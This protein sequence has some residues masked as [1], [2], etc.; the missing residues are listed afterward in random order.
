MIEY[1]RTLRVT[2]PDSK[3]YAAS[4]VRDEAKMGGGEEKV[5]AIRDETLGGVLA[6]PDFIAD[7]VRGIVQFSPIR[8]IATV[9][10]TSRTSVQYRSEPETLRPSGHL[11]SQRERRRRVGLTD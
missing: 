3:L 1:V 10:Q 9:R 4:G 7:V 11:S 6:P 8:E 2:N 5:L